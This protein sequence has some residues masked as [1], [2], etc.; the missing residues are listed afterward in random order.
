MQTGSVFV[1]VI[2]HV[3]GLS[4]RYRLFPYQLADVRCGFSAS[5]APCTTTDCY[6]SHVAAS[7]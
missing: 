1:F 2:A 6:L 5:L 7:S 4:K 3:A